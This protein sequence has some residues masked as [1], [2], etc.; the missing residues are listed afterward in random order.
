MT[1]TLKILREKYT[2]LSI[3]EFAAR[4]GVAVDVLESAERD[5]RGLSKVSAKKISGELKE[6]LTPHLGEDSAE[7]VSQEF[8]AEAISSDESKHNIFSNADEIGTKLDLAR[9]YIDMGDPDGARSILD[10]VLE[11][12]G[13]E[14]SLVFSDDVSPFRIAQF[15]E[16]LSELS[17]CKLVIKSTTILPPDESRI[18]KVV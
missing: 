6:M 12:K 14:L 9:T 3:E 11:G 10:E 13:N 2:N 4:I 8:Y 18:R 5:P 7:L 16:L 15:I 1:H 17:G